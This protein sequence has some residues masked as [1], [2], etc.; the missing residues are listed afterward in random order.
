MSSEVQRV[1]T[2]PVSFLEWMS[3]TTAERLPL[4]PLRDSP[5]AHALLASSCQYLEKATRD[6]SDCFQQEEAANARYGREE[7][8]Y[9]T[10]N[11]LGLKVVLT[12]QWDTQR[13]RILRSLIPDRRYGDA[14]AM[15]EQLHRRVP[16]GTFARPADGYLAR[17]E[18]HRDRHLRNHV[19]LT[20]QLV[21]N[22]LER[23]TGDAIQALYEDKGW[24]VDATLEGLSLIGQ[25]FSISLVA[26]PL[27]A[28]CLDGVR[29]FLLAAAGLCASG[30]ETTFTTSQ[31]SSTADGRAELDPAH[32]SHR[33]GAGVAKK[34]LGMAAGALAL[35]GGAAA[36]GLTG[37]AAAPLVVAGA[38]T[39]LL[40][41]LDL[42]DLFGWNAQVSVTRTSSTTEQATVQVKDERLAFYAEKLKEL[43][44]LFDRGGQHGMW[45]WHGSVSAQSA[46]VARA[47]ADA[48]AGRLSL[49]GNSLS[50]I[51]TRV[52]TSAER[53][54]A[55]QAIDHA[56]VPRLSAP[57]GLL[58]SGYGALVQSSTLPYLFAL[59]QKSHAGVRAIQH[60]PV[61]W[62]AK[63]SG[64]HLVIGE[65]PGGD[66][67]KVALCLRDLTGHLLIAGRTGSG[68]TL[69][70]RSLLRQLQGRLEPPIPFIF[71]DLAQSIQ[72]QD[73][74][75]VTRA[76][77][78]EAGC[79]EELGEPLPPLGLLDFYS[80]LAYDHYVWQISDLLANWLP[81]EGPLSMLMAELIHATLKP[82]LVP[83]T[84][85]WA[86][87]V[88]EVPSLST[89]EQHIDSVL[90][91]ADGGSGRYEGELR[92]N[93]RGAMTTRIRRLTAEPMLELLEGDSCGWIQALNTKNNLLI[94]L[95]RSGSTSERCFLAGGVL[96]TG[97]RHFWAAA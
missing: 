1:A 9:R 28:P 84:R 85:Y 7:A 58:G 29:D 62:S 89:L 51:R 76:K 8:H 60:L 78:Y 21:G 57:V 2:D 26:T 32:R 71:I 81:S 46:S 45:M 40:S 14:T 66:E 93:L 49:M 48:V 11:A 96:L 53:D 43:N 68:K 69:L 6:Y 37:G 92:S 31:S 5:D 95:A 44:T 12:I 67:T 55:D 15:G 22:P 13:Y 4:V 97:H 18:F 74:S 54:A 10:L 20:G 91:D 30:A 77:W 16:F 56:L 25:P 88:A 79:S 27:P 38:A 33:A 64:E 90:L 50:P 35:A 34:V 17:L 86:A 41:S 70:L 80:P 73:W 36:I 87:G 52:V 82:V 83:G 19:L 94:S 59:P 47:V 72:K 61:S 23:A 63:P 24:D 3:H 75:W 42:A 65:R 39:H